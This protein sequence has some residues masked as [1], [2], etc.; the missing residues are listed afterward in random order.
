MSFN[1]IREWWNALTGKKNPPP[2]SPACNPLPVLS[3][4]AWRYSPNL[5]FY[6]CSPANQIKAFIYRRCRNGSA[7]SVYQSSSSSSAMA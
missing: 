2:P 1:S 4:P 5:F 3:G 6:K 7:G